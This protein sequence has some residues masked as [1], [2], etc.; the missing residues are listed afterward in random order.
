MDITI[1]KMTKKT[2]LRMIIKCLEENL[3]DVRQKWEE[4]KT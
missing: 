4:E 2:L 1:D 3:H